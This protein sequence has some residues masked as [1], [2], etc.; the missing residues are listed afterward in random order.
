M[1]DWHSI[2]LAIS[3]FLHADPLLPDFVLVFQYLIIITP[4]E[5]SIGKL[6]L[7]DLISECFRSTVTISE[8]SIPQPHSPKQPAF[9]GVPL[10]KGILSQKVPK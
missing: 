8:D 2:L 7:F 6:F 10:Y 3:P 1:K 9:V 5:K 4:K